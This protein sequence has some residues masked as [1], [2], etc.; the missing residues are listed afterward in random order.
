MSCGLLSDSGEHSGSCA[1]ARSSSS[2]C[3]AP[4]KRC[5][6][7]ESRWLR[8]DGAMGEMLWNCSGGGGQVVHVLPVENKRPEIPGSVPLPVVLL[9][10]FPTSCAH[11]TPLDAPHPAVTCLGSLS[12][13]VTGRRQHRG[14]LR[15]QGTKPTALVLMSF[16]VLMELSPGY[17]EN[18]Q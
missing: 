1:R 14:V 17:E 7:V 4:G 16:N 8:G 5:S 13:A 18:K 15:A 6:S 3:S 10:D 2:F 9:I 12:E 11:R